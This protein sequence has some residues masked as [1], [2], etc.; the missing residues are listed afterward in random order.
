MNAILNRIAIVLVNWVG[1]L[2]MPLW[3]GFV[4]LF[5]GFILPLFSEKQTYDTKDAW[6]A[7]AG[8]KLFLI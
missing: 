2:T 5:I 4:I 6:D 3:G 1:L 8:R 7:W